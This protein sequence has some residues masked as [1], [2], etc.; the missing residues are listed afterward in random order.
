MQSL[1][2]DSARN[3]PTPIAFAAREAMN[4]FNPSFVTCVKPTLGSFS[5]NSCRIQQTHRVFSKDK[6]L[7]A[8]QSA[9][10]L[11][12]VVAQHVASQVE[13]HEIGQR[14]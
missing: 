13:R 8:R 12:R 1:I 10:A 9:Q 2:W 5:G 4:A 3:P 14:P 6:L 11:D 7:E